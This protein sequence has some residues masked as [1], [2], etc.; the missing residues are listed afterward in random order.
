MGR[1]R[2]FIQQVDVCA[3]LLIVNN[4]YSF[5]LSSLNTVNLREKLSPTFAFEKE[6]NRFNDRKFTSRKGHSTGQKLICCTV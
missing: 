3:H 2:D 1:G 6:E 4:Y 5:L